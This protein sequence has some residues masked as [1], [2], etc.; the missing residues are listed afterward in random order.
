MGKWTAQRVASL[1]GDEPEEKQQK[2]KWT[3]QRVAGMLDG[4]R[5]KDAEGYEP[6]WSS[7][8]DTTTVQQRLD[9]AQQARQA[10][11]D[12]ALEQYRE[13]RTSD[14]EAVQMERSAADK[15][16]PSP[17]R[18]PADAG[19]STTG[20]AGKLA[21]SYEKYE[22]E[23]EFDR[24]NAWY[25]TGRNRALADAVRRVDGTNGAYTDADLIKAGWSQRQIDAARQMNA[26]YDALPWAKRTL[27]RAANAAGGVADTVAAAP[28][29]AA[30][31]AVQAGKNWEEERQFRAGLSERERNLYD[32]IRR[33]DGTNG[34]YTDEDLRRAGWSRYEITRMRNRIAELE[35]NDALDTSTSVGYQLYSRGQRLTGAA[36]S[37]LTDTQKFLQG[38]ATSA[39]ENLFVAALDPA[40]VLPVLSAQG[41]GEALAQSAE[42]GTSAGKALLGGAAK[43]GAGWAINSV[44]AADLARTMGSDY[45]KNTVAGKIADAVREL[46]G[47]GRLAQQYP[48]LANAISGG[49][50][51]AVQAFA[52]TY[53]DMAIDAAL[54]DAEAAQSLFEPETFLAA[55]E[56]GAAGGA[57]GAM[58]GAVGTALGAEAQALQKA[59]G[60]DYVGGTN[61]TDVIDQWTADGEAAVAAQQRARAEKAAMAAA[62][63]ATQTEAE[64]EKLAVQQAA[65]E[66]QAEAEGETPS[67]LRSPADAGAA[68]SSPK[69][70]AMDRGMETETGSAKAGTEAERRPETDGTEPGRGEREDT[71]PMAEAAERDAQPQGVEKAVETVESGGAEAEPA[72]DGRG[73]QEAAQE[74][75]TRRV[76][77]AAQ[78]LIRDQ[79][80]GGVSA[81]RWVSAATTLYRLGRSGEVDGFADAL[82]LAQGS[83]GLGVDTAT[84]LARGDTARNAL[85]LAFLQ[86][87]GEAEAGAAADA[88]SL[89]GR[90][91]AQS[92]QGSGTLTF[93]GTLRA[94]NET[95]VRLIALNARATGTDAVLRLKL[96]APDGT[97]GSGASAFIDTETGKIFFGDNA[98]DVFGSVLHEDLHWYN[99]FDREG[100]LA[101]QNSV[102]GMLAREN[103]FEDVESLREDYRRR[104]WNL[105]ESQIDEEIVADA[106]RGLFAEPESFERWVKFQKGQAEQNEGRRGIV[107]KVMDSIKEMLENILGRAKEVL[108]LEPENRAAQRARRL[109]EQEKRILQDEYFAHAE[110]AMDR[111]RGARAQGTKNAVS[112][113]ETAG[114]MRYQID[115]GYAEDLTQWDREGR[116]DG[117][118]FILGSTGDVL[119]GLGARE[120]DIYLN[121]DKVGRILR[122]HPEMTLEE[123]KRIPEV[124]DDPVMVLASRNSGRRADRNTRLVLF[125]SVKAQDG[126][127]VLCVLD[128]Q[129]VEGRLVIDDMQKLNSAYTKDDRP[130]SFVRSSR[131]LYVSENKKRT[132]ALLRSIGFQMPIEL[133]PC[134]SIGSIAY[135]GRS[136]K[137]EGVN[138]TELEV[139]KEGKQKESNPTR[140]PMAVPGSLSGT[141]E[142]LSGNSIAQTE[143]ESKGK[144]AEEGQ[145][146]RGSRYTVLKTAEG[147]LNRRGPSS[148]SIAQTEGESKGNEAGVRYQLEQDAE[149]ADRAARGDVQRQASR[150]IADQN[151]KLRLMEQ[152]MG[153]TRGVKVTDQTLARL[154]GKLLRN[155]GS[156]TDR[157]VVEGQLRALAD[158]L[159]AEGAD[160]EKAQ[161]IAE[162]IAGSILD[163][164]VH[165]DDT[166]WRE[167]P[168]Y[169]RMEYTVAR[170]GQAKEELVRHY[171]SWG[172][173]VDAARRHGVTLRQA[174]GTRDANPAELY[175][176]IV[177]DTRAVGGTGTGAAALFRDAAEKAGTAG[178]YSMEASEWLE[179]LMNVRDAI[180]PK[181]VSAFESE[182][183]Y[184]DARADLAG[185]LLTDLMASDEVANAGRA[186]DARQQ[187]VVEAGKAEKATDAAGRKRA[188]AAQERVR[189]RQAQEL[190]EWKQTTRQVL[191]DYGV[192]PAQSVSGMQKQLVEVMEREAQ[193]AA[194]D[195]QE[196]RQRML[197]DIELA[198]ESEREKN[199]ALAQELRGQTERADRAERQLIVQEDEIRDWETEQKRRSEIYQQVMDG[200]YDM[201]KLSAREQAWAVEMEQAKAQA[202]KERAEMDAEKAK[203]IADRRVKAAREGKER[204]ALRR[205]IRGNA[206][207]LRKML[208]QPTEGNFVPTTLLRQALD[209]A[210]LADAAVLNEGALKKLRRLRDGLDELAKR[211][212]EEEQ[213][214][215]LNVQAL[216]EA[217][218]KSVDEH[219]EQER[220]E[221]EDKLRKAETLLGRA[222]EECEALERDPA[223][224]AQQVRKA[225]DQA[226]RDAAL[227]QR[228]EQRMGALEDAPTKFNNDE[229]RM[230]KAAV[231]GALHAIRTANRTVSEAK[232][233]QIGEMAKQAANEVR[234]SRGN[235]PG[236]PWQGLRDAANR[237]QLD[238]LSAKRVFRRLGGYAKNGMMEQLADML[239][240][241]QRRQTKILL[242]GE[243][244]FARV[245]G[246]KHAKEA[247]AFAGPGAELVD[248]GLKDTRGNPA[249]LTHAQLCS[250]YMHLRNEDSKNHLMNGGF[251]IPD[252]KLYQKGEVERAYQ[253]GQN[254]LLGLVEDPTGQGQTAEKTVLTAIEAA[255]TDYD[256]AWVQCMEEFFGSYTTNLINETSRKLL[257]F[258]RATVKNYYPIAVDKSAL[259]QQIE[260]LKRDATIEGRGMLKQR[261]KSGAPILLEEC[262]AVVERSLRD[263]AAYAGLAAPI[264]DVNRVLNS[265]V[266]LEDGA[267]RLKNKII[268]ERWGQDAVDYI[269]EL[270]TD[271]QTGHR[272]RNNTISKLARRLRP[273]YAGAV[274]TLNVG[275]AL[276]QTASL[277]TAAAVLGTGA[278]MKAAGQFLKNLSPAELGRIEAEMRQHGDA[279][280]QYRLRGTGTAEL[281]SIGKKRGTVQAL[282]EKVPKALT[283][284]I[285]KM[286]E[287]TVASLWEGAKDYVRT[288]PEEMREDAG[289]GTPSPV[290]SPADAGAAGSSPK[291]GAETQRYWDAVNRVFARTVEETQPNY[292]TMQRAGIQRSDSELVQSMTMFTTQRFQNYGILAD[293]VGDWRAQEARY[294]EEPT[295]ANRAEAQRARQQ[296]S[297]ACV[298]QAVQTA[299]FCLCKMAGDFILHKWDRL[300]DENGDITWES[301]LKRFASLYA[302]NA[303]GIF[304][305]GSELYTLADNVI[306]GTDYD[307]M[308]VSG[309]S[310]LNDVADDLVRFYAEAKKDTGEMDAE[311][312]EAHYT[313]LMKRGTTLTTDLLMTAAIPAGNAQTL[314]RAAQA[315]S[316]DFKNLAAGEGF[317]F[318]GPPKSAASQY[319]RLAQAVLDGDREE[320]T[321]A[322][323]KLGMLETEGTLKDAHRKTLSAL[324]TRLKE[325]DPDLAAA[326]Q[327]QLAGDDAAR[328]AA[329]QALMKRMCEAMGLDRKA[330]AA[331]QAR[332]ELIDL[333]QSATSEKVNEALR[334]END[335]V[336]QAL[337]QAVTGWDARTAQKELD[338]LMQAGKDRAGL[339]SAI[340]A[341][342]REEYRAGSESDRKEMEKTLLAL[343]DADGKALY[344]EKEIGKWKEEKEKKADEWEKWR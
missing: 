134:G 205:S 159:K 123:I 17:L 100:G 88:Q 203:E 226:Y 186:Q 318:S 97:D 39:A 149:E 121:G 210:Q 36:Q 148:N 266:D 70:G 40:A 279:L 2:E 112:G 211:Q 248:I 187:E 106:V 284:W 232:T 47:Q 261:V 238:M 46:A 62:A 216:L 19:A 270:L 165:R 59:L 269:D 105:S 5:E 118:R 150:A 189:A 181:T 274:L 328:Y 128:L 146:K 289:D 180:A 169:H 114:A 60:D 155:N 56:S 317:S 94:E 324:K 164:A 111:Y 293:A 183:E 240:E 280:L 276:G 133:Q 171:G 137:I 166:L 228:L 334:G 260:G 161:S 297:R 10:R 69:G 68:G 174:D 326:V 151:A 200:D 344:T 71:L 220:M 18:S 230:L 107:R 96:T 29:L 172:D 252:A 190:E 194:Q 255:M 283:G 27:R 264:R 278:T 75:R 132:T 4:T 177:N 7:G 296:L 81:E 287:I 176:S 157:K 247:K 271:L 85:E 11:Y 222:Q 298:S 23:D 43:F 215:D 191:E 57:S 12:A 208:L 3:A 93:D 21:A 235:E 213:A 147:E 251:I 55:L 337:E 309:L 170:G 239:N 78:E 262:G 197:D 22:Q 272:K 152:A 73:R 340:T 116:P 64:Q 99:S 110:Q 142:L 217:V 126:R 1:M 84:V 179:I 61:W 219:R 225:R 227:V 50:D 115:P 31:T 330:A 201:D 44:G 192:K 103:G 291:G 144:T 109:A 275:V 26:R 49:V 83:R 41:A 313:A 66:E 77:E 229:L 202:K 95:D 331:A 6:G 285:T 167:Y 91:G 209:V 87:R 130:V 277:P 168:E 127:P 263:T 292:T 160:M 34:A 321:A 315:W 242:E 218:Q 108:A 304:L 325:E 89:G 212:G 80:P 51:N 25:D 145:I 119:Q 273:N 329:Q 308:S 30:E 256:R 52:E 193:R 323:E 243:A 316:E 236:G 290:S 72:A 82:R 28:I 37:G 250:L 74:L 45:A 339:K 244:L 54:G 162:D 342:A 131:V 125:G 76:S 237:Y 207:Q 300:R 15:G 286:D 138:F 92:L 333:I 253:K 175:E 163:G 154:A 343:K 48:A 322:L 58:G 16:T 98:R 312:L 231:S 102:L 24:I 281:A 195:R 9:N 184:A 246:K 182:A 327:A 307:V 104:Y 306:H 53:A 288:H 319:D 140:L 199:R 259:A 13:A 185:R 245:T 135:T 336:T 35:A 303:A 101:F 198:L 156:R 302:G 65:R 67:H 267:G 320:G 20:L 173:A 268:R 257:G 196:A 254:V 301:L 90:T 234:A 153:L 249:P 295:E 124:L 258:E 282:G 233:R 38:A 158:Y 204:D 332:S 139:R 113:E 341:A 8:G 338:R 335:R 241:G 129:P 178:A 136:V 299:V 214:R 223:A 265:M 120:S 42:A 32:A 305:L 206:T 63:K 79:M 141:P 143:G 117:V 311:Q 122:E 221:L 86:G 294:R 224:T 14:F 33:V 310:T 314:M 188:L